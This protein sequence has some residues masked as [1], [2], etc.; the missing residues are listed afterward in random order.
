MKTILKELFY[1]LIA[2]SIGAFL[3]LIYIY[4]TGGF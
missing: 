4:R 2:L 1:I 3:G